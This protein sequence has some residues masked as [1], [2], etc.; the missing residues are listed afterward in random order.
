M[1]WASRWR[2]SSS[3]VAPERPT[4]VHAP[5]VLVTRPAHDAARWV[6]AL[7]QL[8][9]TAL[10][11]PLIQIAPV[12]DPTLRTAL[13]QAQKRWSEYRAVM[14]VSGNAVTHFFESKAPLALMQQAQAAIKPRVWAPGPGTVRALLACGVEATLIDGP[15]ADAA[16]FDSE[17]LWQ[18]VAP[19]VGAGDRVLIVRG[20]SEPGALG[21][22]GREWLAAQVAAAGASVDFVA[23]YERRAPS[24][25]REQATL[26]RAAA[27]NGSLWLF[28]SGEALS[29][30]GTLLPGQDWS[31]ARALATH[32]RIAQRALATG[33]GKVTACRPS[34][35]EV[36]ASIKSLHE[37]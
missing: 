1:H 6:Q 23:A 9:I 13:V 20:S 27:S 2:R 16:Q 19:Q 8:G 37:H 33:F 5:Q 22:Q 15:A 32:P 10:A 30:L 28:S 21:G 17:A 24:F 35:A 14:F 36:A 12:S 11:L 29:H 3:A 26:A 31:A 34:L 25:T 18:R 4:E 7:G